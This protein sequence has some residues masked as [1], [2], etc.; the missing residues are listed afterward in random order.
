MYGHANQRP[1]DSVDLRGKGLTMGGGAGK[2][3]AT[4][5]ALFLRFAN[6]RAVFD[7][8]VTL[9]LRAHGHVGNLSSRNDH[10]VLWRYSTVRLCLRYHSLVET[11]I[12]FTRQ[13]TLPSHKFWRSF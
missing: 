7:D 3:I 10:R 1:Q 5:L 2:R 11:L 8:V 9:A 4:L 12:K 6:G 13:A